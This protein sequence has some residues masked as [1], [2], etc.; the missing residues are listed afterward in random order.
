MRPQTA[1]PVI[2]ALA[3]LAFTCAPSHA[4][5]ATRRVPSWDGRAVLRAHGGVSFPI[6]NFGSGYQTGFGVGGSIGYGVSEHVLISGGAAY[7]KFDHEV[8]GGNEASITP[9]TIGVDYKIPSKS[10]IAPWFGGGFGVYHVALIQQLPNGV[11]QSESENNFGI[12]FGVGIGAP[13]GDKLLLGTGLKFHYVGG[14][15][16]IDTPFVTYQIGIAAVL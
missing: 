11:T 4:D 8:I 6:G 2:V 10:T 15:N 1:L 5:A 16:F 3:A 12:N 7:H 9:L 13:I 14:D